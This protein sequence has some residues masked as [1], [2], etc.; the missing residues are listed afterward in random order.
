M[1]KLRANHVFRR[2]LKD[3]DPND[4][5]KDEKV[6]TTIEKLALKL[7]Q[8]RAN[9]RKPSTF[10]VSCI[11]LASNLV[12]QRFIGHELLSKEEISR[13]CQIP[14]TTLREHCRFLNSHLKMKL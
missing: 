14:S 3:L 6:L 11:F 4:D 8:I 13:V 2:K 9:G 1:A 5:L 12:G 10:S 7:S